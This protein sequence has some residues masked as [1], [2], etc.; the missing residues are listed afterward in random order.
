[1]NAKLNM[2]AFCL[3]QRLFAL[4]GDF[5]MLAIGASNANAIDCEASAEFARAVAQL[6]H[7]YRKIEQCDLVIDAARD[8]KDQSYAV[9]SEL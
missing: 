7:A 5:N 2:R 3:K 8:E 9:F 4:V 1:M 6:Q